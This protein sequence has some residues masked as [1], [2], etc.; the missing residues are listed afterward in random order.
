LGEHFDEGP[1]FAVFKVNVVCSMGGIFGIVGGFEG[2][3]AA[4]V[5]IGW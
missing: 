5:V 3:D 2:V 4:D 1:G